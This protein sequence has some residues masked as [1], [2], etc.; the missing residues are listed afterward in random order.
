MGKRNANAN[1][2]LAPI[3]G[4][5]RGEGV[6]PQAQSVEHRRQLRHELQNAARVERPPHPSPL[7]RRG[8]G[9]FLEG[10][11]RGSYVTGGIIQ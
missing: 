9:K 11:H 4:E 8:R 2:S 3:G 7:P 10:F 5:G 6:L 1:F